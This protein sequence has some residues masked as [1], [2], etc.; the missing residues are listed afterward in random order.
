[1]DACDNRQQNCAQLLVDNGH[2][3]DA[4]TM[5]TTYQT[6]HRNN[7]YTAAQYDKLF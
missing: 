6:A 3:V 4:K 5:V 1:M 2:I 7:P